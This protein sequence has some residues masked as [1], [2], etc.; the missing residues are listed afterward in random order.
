MLDTPVPI[1]T[2]KLGNLGQAGTWI[3]NGWGTLSTTGMVSYFDAVRK[4]DSDSCC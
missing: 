1:G 4:M 2:L 3:G